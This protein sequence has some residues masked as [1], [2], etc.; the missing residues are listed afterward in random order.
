MQGTHKGAGRIRKRRLKGVCCGLLRWLIQS[1]LDTVQSCPPGDS[2]I[3]AY[4]RRQRQAERKLQLV[5]NGWLPRRVKYLDL[6]ED[7]EAESEVRELVCTSETE[8]HKRQ[9]IRHKS[10][11]ILIWADLTGAS[12]SSA[13]PPSR[14]ERIRAATVASRKPLLADTPTTGMCDNTE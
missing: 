13:R 2:R 7:S 4:S 6:G 14:A 1:C 12:S 3:E 9:L 11:L 5:T 10:Q 8:R